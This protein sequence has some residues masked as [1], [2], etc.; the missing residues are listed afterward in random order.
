MDVNYVLKYF[1]F[2]NL[3]AVVKMSSAGSDDN[4]EKLSSSSL[5]DQHE[6]EQQVHVIKSTYNFIWVL[7]I[8]FFYDFAMMVKIHYK[9]QGEI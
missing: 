7:K 5:I 3:Q 6:H 2:I 4:Q 9:L 1:D 8:I